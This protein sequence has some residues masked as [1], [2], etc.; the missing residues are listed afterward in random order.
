M[1]HQKT[2]QWLKPIVLLMLMPLLLVV[3]HSLA[4][5]PGA[6]AW[7]ATLGGLATCLVA[8]LQDNPWFKASVLG[9]L[10]MNVLWLAL[11]R[12]EDVAWLAM[13]YRFVWL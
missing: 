6:K 1:I 3:L 5:A 13:L 7:L 9:G 12:D 10:L 11:Y 2:G 8:L 4:I